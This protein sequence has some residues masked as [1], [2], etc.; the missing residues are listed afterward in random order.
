M[1]LLGRGNVMRFDTMSK[2][3]LAWAMIVASSPCSALAQAEVPKWS[4]VE[5]N[6]T[7][8]GSSSNWYTDANASVIGTFRGPAGV[9]K[10]VNGFWDGGRSVKIRFTPTVQGHWTYR[11]SSSNSG[12]NGK[13]GKFDCVKPTPPKHGFLRVDAIHPYSFVWDDG[14]RYFMWGQTY[15]DV[16][17][18]ALANDHWKESVEKA[19]AYGMNKIRMHVYAQSLYK[20][21]VEFNGYPD[22]QPYLGASTS[23]DRDRLNIPY[24]RKLD[25]M[26]QYMGSKE[27]AADL[28]V[29]NPYWDNREFGTE[30]QNDRLVKYVVA[31]YA[32]YT[33]VIWCLAN[34][35]NL[36][37]TGNQ[38]KGAYPQN[39][40]A[41]DRMGK[42]LS[43]NDPWRAQGEF[44]RPLSIHNTTIAFEFFGS[45]WPTYAIIQYGGWNPD[46]T[47]GDQWGNVGIVHNLGHRMPVVNDEYGYIGQIDPKPPIRVS[48]TRTRLRQAIWGIAT[49]GGY[50]SAGDFRVTPSQMGNPE[51][52]G[53]WYDAPEEYGDLKIMI[54]FFTSTG[55]EYWKMS[56]QNGLVTT[57][58]RTYVLAELS[59]QYVIYAAVGGSFS[60]ELAPGTYNIRRYDPRTAAVTDLGVVLGGGPRSF[61]MPDTKDWVV[62]LNRIPTDNQGTTIDR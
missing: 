35:W 47:N 38:Y 60:L 2:C 23:P 16:V 9:T 26:V 11:T 52:T 25:E 34:E 37:A 12:L 7:P 22:S 44:L 58:T 40:A 19:F 32:G 59:R 14:T 48:M 1:L 49:A 42:I 17:I 39:K 8:S 15:Y 36:S 62:F 10:R 46:Y 33:N 4:V 54:D 5:V 51:I 29:T 13:T 53:D 56:S 55:I 57:G 20:Q 28:I 41:F 24:W 27:M 43:A 30:E 50:G 6:L 45:T 21:G 31:R 18:S 3:A 61:T